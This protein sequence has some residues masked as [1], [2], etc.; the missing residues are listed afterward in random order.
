ML[1]RKLGS[2][3]QAKPSE[4]DEFKLEMTDDITLRADELARR[5]QAGIRRALEERARRRDGA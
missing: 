5:A 4:A 1:D 2:F 3:G